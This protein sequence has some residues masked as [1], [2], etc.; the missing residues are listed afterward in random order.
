[1]LSN[2]NA[3]VPQTQN[4][5]VANGSGPSAKVFVESI[6]VTQPAPHQILVK[7]S[8]SGLCASDKSLLRDEWS[9]F[10]KMVPPMAASTRG[11]AGHEGAGTVVAVGDE[12]SNIWKVGDRAGVKWIESTCGVCEMCSNGLDEAHCPSAVHHAV[13]VAGTFQEYCVTD[14]RYATKIPEGVKDEEAGPIMCGGLSAYV[15]CKRSAVKPGQWIVILGGGGGV[16]H[17]ALQYA[18]AMGMRVIAIDGG[19]EKE[20][21][22]RKLG[23]EEFI[24]YGELSKS[25]ESTSW[26]A[27][28]TNKT[29]MKR[30]VIS[31]LPFTFQNIVGVPLMFEYTTYFFQLI[32]VDDPFLGNIVKP[33]ALVVGIIIAFYTISLVEIPSPSLRAKT[34]SIAVT[35]QY[36]TGILFNY[37]V[38]LMLSNQYAG[39]GQKIGLFFGGIT[40]LYLIPC[41]L[42]FPETKGSTYHELDELFDRRIPAWRFASAKTSH[43]EELETKA[44]LKE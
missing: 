14:G 16:G 18:K 43:Q 40:L 2:E 19:K 35:S 26:K 44:M 24:D 20:Q 31:T 27:I 7:I 1:M 42:L 13:E 32:G 5:A 23:A 6:P 17:F 39:W 11:I 3:T 22:C 10:G 36:L 8:W 38:L 4:A 34:T 41:V 28:F 29:N 33:M 12:V 37:C 25:S 9:A 21:M 15:A 30:A